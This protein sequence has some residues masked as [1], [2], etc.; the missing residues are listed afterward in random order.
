MIIDATDL[1]AG[2]LA[3]SIAKKALLGETIDVVN[4]E[5]LVLTG[6]KI[7]GKYKHKFF[8]RCIPDDK[9]LPDFL[10]PY[11]VHIKFRKHQDNKYVIFILSVFSFLSINTF[12]K[13]P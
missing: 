4:C 5:N 7:Y 10:V 1:V 12:Q 3:S 9:R 13:K 11:K 6:N 2:R 8:Y